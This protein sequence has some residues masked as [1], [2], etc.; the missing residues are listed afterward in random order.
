[1]RRRSV[2]ALIVALVVTGAPVGADEVII[3]PPVPEPWVG[4]AT[5]FGGTGIHDTGEWIWQDFI[6]DDYGADTTP[7]GA[8]QR[9]TLAA[10]RGDFRYPAGDAYAGNAADIAEVRVRADGDDLDVRVTLNTLVDPAVPIIGVAVDTGD[11]DVRLWPYDA[12]VRSPWDVFATVSGGSVYLDRADGSA[13]G[14]GAHVD[15]DANTI[16]LRIPGVATGDTLRLNVGAGLQQP[17]SD[18]PS[19][20]PVGPQWMVGLPGGVVP[21]TFNSGGPSLTR[22]F[23]LAFNARELEPRGGAW[24]EDAQAQALLIGDVADFGH[25]VDLGKL[26]AGASETFELEPG[27]Y[28]A[29]FR[30]RQ[31]LGAGA[32]DSF[33]QYRSEL[34]PYGLWIPQDYDPQEPTPLFL[35][36]HSLSVHH[37]QYRG[38]E[39]ATSYFTMYEQIGDARGAIVAT[40]LARGPDG[41]YRNEAFVDTLEV[42]N[43][44]QSRFLIDPDRITLGGY[45]MGGYGTYRLGTLFPELF[46]SAVSW[47]GVPTDFDRL[48]NMQHIPTMIVHGTNDELV[49]ITGVRE[50]AARFHELGYEYRFHEHPGMDHLTFVWVDEWSR[51]SAWIAGRERVTDPARVHFKVRPSMWTTDKDDA[52]RDVILGH[53]EALGYDLRSSYWV[54]DVQNALE[55]AEVEAV[56]AAIAARVPQTTDMSGVALGPPTPHITNGLDRTLGDDATAN[57]LSLRLRGVAGATIVL[58]EAAIS[59]ASDIELTTDADEATV[60]LLAGDFAAGAV[61]VDGDGNTVPSSVT[62]QGLEVTVPAGTATLTVSS[63]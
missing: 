47:A 46:S 4:D 11:A 57:A 36:L 44:V 61:V 51:E 2:L 50:Q 8:A 40:P 62:A 17:C 33:P 45:S 19:A 32:G 29:I 31:D 23:D 18:L 1:M 21:G 20:C 30:S 3:G 59:T 9:V 5:M 39:N 43:D 49:P 27:F 14:Y 53:V 26:H 22:V 48:E 63:A 28:N 60:I 12:G 37:N 54:R 10:T 41:W 35:L 55:M 15:V 34:Q 16:D 24:Q 7:A 52:E 38:G 25:D 56:S 6:F 42:F 58:A 13:A